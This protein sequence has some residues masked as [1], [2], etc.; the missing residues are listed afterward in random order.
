MKPIGAIV[1]FLVMWQVIVVLFSIPSFTLPTPLAIFDRMVSDWTLLL[2]NAWTT[3]RVILAGFSA[4]VVGGM[5]LATVIVHSRFVRETLYPLLVASQLV[6]QVAIAPLLTIWFGIGDLP[7][8]IVAFLISFFPMVVNTSRGMAGVNE[9][10]IYLMRGLNASTWQI[11]WKIRIPNALPMVFAGMRISITLAVIGAVVGEFVAGSSG[12]GYLVF[13]GTANI[14]TRLTF[15]AIAWLSVLGLVL[16]GLVVWAEH[17][18]VPWARS[19]E[20]PHRRAR[21]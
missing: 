6:P 16:F 12:L 7:K 17:F 9:D 4:A 3:L 18:A 11:L 13:V 19:M 5:I 15:S 14:D 20:E 8:V 2:T 1:V 21:R 10:L